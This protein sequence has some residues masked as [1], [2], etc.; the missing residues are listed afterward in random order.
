[1]KYYDARETRDPAVREQELLARLPRQVAHAKAHAPAFAALLQDVDPA[2]AQRVGA[3]GTVQVE[4]TV[5]PDGSVSNVRAV[6]TNAPREFSREFERE[7]M[8]AVRRW[9][10]QPVAQATTTRRT[11]AFDM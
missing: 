2:A 10:F 6:S 3:S 9:R 4:F 1:M 11:I 5:N 8:S 7:A